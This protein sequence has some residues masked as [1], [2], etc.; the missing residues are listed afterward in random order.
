VN[1]SAY[2]NYKPSRIEWI[3]SIPEH[4]EVAQLRRC[5]RVIN[6]GTPASSEEDYWEGDINWFTPEDLGRNQGKY[7][8]ESRRK[9]SRQGLEN[10]SAELSPKYSVII[11]TRAP[12]GHAALLAVE[13]C[14]N[15]GCRL[16]AT[17]FTKL[18]PDYAYYLV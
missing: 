18:T 8:Y 5:C 7:I 9:I 6:G 2:P 3:S 16:L 1:F 4:W 14:C 10:C 11:S 13:G 15:Q 12:I 17:D